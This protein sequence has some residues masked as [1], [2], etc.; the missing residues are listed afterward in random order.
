MERSFDAQF[1]DIKK[2][3]LSMGGH[4]EKALDQAVLCLLQRDVPGFEIVHQIESLINQEQIL[5]DNLCLSFLAKQGPV[6]RDLR[7]ILSMIKINTDL[8]R[9]GDQCVN[10]AYISCDYIKRGSKGSLTRID[11]MAVIAK[12]MV[13]EALQSFVNSNVEMA[14]Q[15]LK[16]DDRL[17]ELKGIV[18]KE[19]LQMMKSEPEH[20]EAALD[21]ILMARN[22][23]RMGDHATNI[24]EDVIFI[25]TG[26]DIR[27][28]GHA[29]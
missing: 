12:K 20:S 4:V 24:A 18:F 10:I 21:L 11:E 9:M 16:S 25:L 13:Y 1:E 27:H 26:K 19:M 15:V 22:L 23:E 14:Q 3:I 6:A 7:S 2:A 28:G 5:I 17:D 29:Q 8:E